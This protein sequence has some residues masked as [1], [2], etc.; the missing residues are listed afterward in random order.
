MQ[1]LGENQFTSDRKCM[2]IIVRTPDGRIVLYC[3]GADEV[4]CIA[5]ATPHSGS[6]GVLQVI[7]PK[8]RQD[9]QGSEEEVQM[10]NHLSAFGS[11]GLRTLVIGRVEIPQGARFRSW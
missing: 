6:L 1:L 10:Q 5:H 9:Q 11:D 4:L 8:L 3:K 2:S 7:F